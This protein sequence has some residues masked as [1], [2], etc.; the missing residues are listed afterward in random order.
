MYKYKSY[1]FFQIS[2]DSKYQK[3]SSGLNYHDD[4]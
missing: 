1:D 4:Y 3:I 2:C